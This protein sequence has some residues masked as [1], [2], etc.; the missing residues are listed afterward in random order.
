MSGR[1][2]TI[3]EV[4]RFLENQPA[5][6]K[7][8]HGEVHPER[9]SE[10][11]ARPVYAAHI[12]HEQWGLHLIRP[13]MNRWSRWKPGSPCRSAAGAA[14]RHQRAKTYGKIFRCVD[15]LPAAIAVNR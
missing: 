11:F 1:F 4:K 5:W 12:T 13:S 7:D 14:R 9:I 2:E 10:V 6:P 8:K 15:S 3:V